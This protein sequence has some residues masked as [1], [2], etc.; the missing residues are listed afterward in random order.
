MSESAIYTAEMLKWKQKTLFT[1]T[2]IVVTS[3]NSNL[4]ETNAIYLK[5]EALKFLFQI[6]SKLKLDILTRRPTSGNC[7]E[8]ARRVCL[9]CQSTA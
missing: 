7:C 5:F 3:F 4:T 8:L 6:I 9:A 1:L 2:K